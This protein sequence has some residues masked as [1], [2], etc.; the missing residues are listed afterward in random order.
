M[1]KILEAINKILQT[2]LTSFGPGWAL[3]IVFLACVLG[4]LYKF[5]GDWVKRNETNHIVRAKDETIQLLAQDNRDL[6]V[7]L[8]KYLGWSDEAVKNIVL[9]NIPKDAIEARKLLEKDDKQ[10]KTPSTRKRTS[11]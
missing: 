9:E 10:T 8:F 7:I 6:R 3:L 5:Y 2:L 11:K 4:F 1:D